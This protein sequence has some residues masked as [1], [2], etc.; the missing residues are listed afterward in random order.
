[1]EVVVGG[2]DDRAFVALYHRDGRLTAALGVSRPKQVMPF[3]RLL[4]ERATID[5]ARTLAAS[6]AV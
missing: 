1:V 6:F 2:P 4:A 3:R 5:E